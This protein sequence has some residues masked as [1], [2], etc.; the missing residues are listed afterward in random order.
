MPYFGCE[1]H[2]RWN[3]VEST[4]NFIGYVQGIADELGIKIRS[5]ADWDMD[6]NF[7]DQSFMDLPHFELVLEI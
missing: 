2:I 5:G 4:Y 6:N 1:P 7:H 3:D